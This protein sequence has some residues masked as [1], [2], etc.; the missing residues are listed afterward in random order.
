M[1]ILTKDNIDEFME[2][3]HYLHDSSI[4]KVDY[5]PIE[6]KIEMIINIYWS[7]EPTIKS[8]GT[9]DTDKS[10]IK[11]IFTGVNE[12][13]D[14]QDYSSIDDSSVEYYDKDGKELIGISLL[15]DYLDEEPLIHVVCGKIEYEILDNK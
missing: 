10:R 4:N 7:G 13:N 5:N 1:N 2:Y 8:D 15:C 14:N 3:Y 11:M 6:E 9:Y 12:Y